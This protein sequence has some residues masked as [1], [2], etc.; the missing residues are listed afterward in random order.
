VSGRPWR[1]R[2]RRSRL[3]AVSLALLPILAAG[4]A[5]IA[6]SPSTTGRASHAAPARS[7]VDAQLSVLRTPRTS[8]N[9]LPQAFGQALQRVFPQGRPD[10]AAGRKV[11]ASD[12]EAAY[13]VPTQGGVCVIN[14][15]GEVFCAPAA[16]L[17]GADGVN[18][19]SPTL[20]RGQVELEW[21]LP[22][23]AS[24][25]AVRLASGAERTFASGF[26]VD[27]RVGCRRRPSFGRRRRSGGRAQGELRP[28]RRSA[29]PLGSSLT[30]P[31]SRLEPRP[32]VQAMC[33][34]FAVS[35]TSPSLVRP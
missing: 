20:P 19:C 23:G 32:D 21:L 4:G 35:S 16:D 5:A 3:V 2:S 6:V 13:L 14:P 9:E 22:D 25:V 18:L 29:A 34:P 31:P 28:P 7:P 15:K 10:A 17:A 8:A 30:A 26:N 24:S 1:G 12:G 11:T 27:D 33:S